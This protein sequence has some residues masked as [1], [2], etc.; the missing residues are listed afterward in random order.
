MNNESLKL[1]SRRLKM[2]NCMLKIKQIGSQTE[3]CNLI[4]CITCNYT[5]LL[6]GRRT[7][8]AK[9]LHKTI[10]KLTIDYPMY[11]Y[12]NTINDESLL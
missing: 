10:S 11:F 12:R 8:A 5:I 3:S 7:Q 6:K 2:Y 1:N 4:V 9:Q